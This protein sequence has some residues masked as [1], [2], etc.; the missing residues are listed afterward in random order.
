VTDY[1]RVKPIDATTALYVAGS[2]VMGPMGHELVPLENRD[3]AETFARDHG[4]TE[5][6]LFDE[7]TP[8]KIPR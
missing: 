1:Y 3:D 8:A 5:I 6:L 2:D 4:G 7:V